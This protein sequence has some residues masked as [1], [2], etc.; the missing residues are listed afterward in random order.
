MGDG[1]T[2]KNGGNLAPVAPNRPSTGQIGTLGPISVFM[3]PILGQ[4]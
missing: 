1:L 4:N 3:G 2:K